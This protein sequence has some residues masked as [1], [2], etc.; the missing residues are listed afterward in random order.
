MVNLVLQ[1][2][3]DQWFMF[4]ERNGPYEILIDVVGTPIEVD[5]CKSSTVINIISKDSGTQEIF[6]CILI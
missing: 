5:L 6:Q 1:K 4:K 2:D 3:L